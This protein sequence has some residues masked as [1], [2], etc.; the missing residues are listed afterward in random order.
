MA[1]MRSVVV[2]LA[3]NALVFA[4]ILALVSGFEVNTTLKD[5]VFQAVPS[6]MQGLGTIGAAWI[7]YLAFKEWRR[8]DDAKRRADTAQLIIRQSEELERAVL[9]A[10]YGTLTF[11]IEGR[12]LSLEDKMQSAA[13]AAKEPMTDEVALAKKELHG[14]RTY[15]TEAVAL[16]KGS[17]VAE[18]M[19]KGEALAKAVIQ[20]HSMLG[21]L[22]ETH[23]KMLGDKRFEEIVNRTLARLGIR[24]S[25]DSGVDD[26]A[27]TVE[28]ELQTTFDELREKLVKVLVTH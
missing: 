16:Y 8:P 10:R 2:A 18:L 21:F 12:V 3:A 4:V 22:D 11:L 9:S 26:G 5:W 13:D 19:D 27:E 6:Y 24:Y 28:R 1:E 20:D 14:F 17:G 15:R 23:R 25:D 7:G